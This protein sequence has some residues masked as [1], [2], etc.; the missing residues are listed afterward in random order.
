MP[1]LRAVVGD[2]APVVT[3]RVPA[4][5]HGFQP[6]HV[7]VPGSGRPKGKGNLI[8]ADTRRE[9]LAGIAAHGSDGKGSGG[10]AGAVYRAVA[11]NPRNAVSLLCAITPRELQADIRRTEVQIT[12][13][14]DLDSELQRMGLPTTDRLF[15]RPIFECD[16]K[17]TPVPETEEAEVVEA[18]V[19]ANFPPT[20]GS[21]KRP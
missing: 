13:L 4:K 12:S 15:A 6:G 16:F 2:R 7:K 10:V 5:P 19:A 21:K 8:S 3:E 18:E 17:G 11:D 20:T 1:R 9:I 14:A